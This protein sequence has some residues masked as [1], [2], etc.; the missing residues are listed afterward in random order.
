MFYVCI[1]SLGNNVKGNGVKNR[2]EKDVKKMYEKKSTSGNVKEAM[3]NKCQ[4]NPVKQ[5]NIEV[6]LSLE[7]KLCQSPFLGFL[8][9]FR[10]K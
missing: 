1:L 4:E 8:L 7:S 5:S 3:S 6:L 10:L 9:S 2:Q